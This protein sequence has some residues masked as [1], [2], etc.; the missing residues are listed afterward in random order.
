MKLLQNLN[1]IFTYY[2]CFYLNQFLG[3]KVHVNATCIK[4]CSV[5]LEFVSVYLHFYQPQSSDCLSWGLLYT[6]YQLCLGTW[7]WNS[8]KLLYLD[9]LHRI[10][11]LPSSYNWKCLLRVLKLALKILLSYG[12]ITWLTE[13]MGKACISKLAVRFS[14]VVQ[15]NHLYHEIIFH[16]VSIYPL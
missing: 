14:C 4:L 8:H 5:F 10:P 1:Y 11:I 9:L 7:S 13:K 2:L 16:L 12:N 3:H 6:V 15:F